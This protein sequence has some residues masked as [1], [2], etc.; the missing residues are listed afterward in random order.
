MLIE[1]VQAELFPA[2]TPGPVGRRG[3]V[4]VGTCS[5]TDPSLIKAK[6]FYPRGCSSAE[7]RLVYY[8]SQFPLV[9]VDSSF[10]ALPEPLHAQ[11][12]AQRTPANFVF[13]VKAFRLLTG[14]QTPPQVFPP[15]IKPHL[16]PLTGR[17]KNYY[18]ADL[19]GDLRDELWRRFILALAPLKDAGKLR[20]VHF[21]FAPWVTDEPAW[22]A[23]VEHCVERMAG[24]LLAVEFRNQT[25][26]N[27]RQAGNTLAWEREL[28][29]VHVVVDEPQGVGN[30]AQGVW[31]VT[32]P[33]LAVVRLHGRNAETWTGK[34]TTASSERFNY[35]YSDGELEELAG[36]IDSL[37]D[38]VFDL[39]VL[40]NVNFEDQGIRAARKLARIMK[41]FEPPN[42]QPS[43][44]GNQKPAASDLG[45]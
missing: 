22:R 32:N 11:L 38:E 29:V 33:Q 7:Q 28:G 5:W 19:P 27:D 14:H 18:Y 20:A 8:A 42:G 40:V 3:N 41:D 9:E 23:H 45:G 35:E 2:E 1:P 12:W 43:G 10:F 26:L 16:P 17:K 44:G 15:D 6:T 25:W 21:Q 34:G 31:A 24:H 13:N 4:R 30:Y 36:R 37:A 39:Q